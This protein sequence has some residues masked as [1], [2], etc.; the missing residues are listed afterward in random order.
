M[1]VGIPGRPGIPSPVGVATPDKRRE[2]R[3]EVTGVASYGGCVTGRAR[4]YAAVIT[5][6]VTPVV[7][8]AGP[9]P[10]LTR[11]RRSPG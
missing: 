7:G 10:A 2:C 5:D 9:N 3:S 4:G 6:P 11:N 1:R 8:E